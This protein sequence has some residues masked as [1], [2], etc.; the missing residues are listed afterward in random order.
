MATGLGL[1][2]GYALN[3]PKL[4]PPDKS[5]TEQMAGTRVAMNS[6]FGEDLV[7]EIEARFEGW[8]EHADW[9]TGYER[10]PQDFE[11]IAQWLESL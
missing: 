7:T 8:P 10:T 6:M 5:P 2:V 9:G 3:N 4:L 1:P 11:S